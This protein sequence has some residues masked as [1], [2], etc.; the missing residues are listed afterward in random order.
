MS[1]C[2]KCECYESCSCE[3]PVTWR[4][5]NGTT[6]QIKDMKTSHVQNCITKIKREN[7]RM[8]YL[9]ILEQELRNRN[10]RLHKILK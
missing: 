3:R 7:W 4:S 10:S 1:Y 9:E 2:P 8:E 5:A 6:W